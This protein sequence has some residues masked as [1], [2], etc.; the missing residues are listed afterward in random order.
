[1]G[2]FNVVGESTEILIL[3]AINKWVY[4]VAKFKSLSQSI[5]AVSAQVPIQ[6]TS[7]PAMRDL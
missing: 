5:N 7:D 3:K 2:Q 6:D 4:T 1:M